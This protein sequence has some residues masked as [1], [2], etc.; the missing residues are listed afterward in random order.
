MGGVVLFLFLLA[1]CASIPKGGEQNDLPISR[2]EFAAKPFGFD[3]TLRNFEDNYK[4]VLKKQRYFITIPNTGRV[5]TIYNFHKGKKTKILFHKYGRFE[6][7]IIGGKIRR[8]Q[9]ELNNGIRTGLSRKEFFGKFTDWEYDESNSLILESP[10]IRCT[11]TF[12]FSRNKLKEIKFVVK[13][14]NT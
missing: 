14:P 3:L 9:I 1:S 4:N 11:F 13:R 12:V 10:S 7:R 6:G 5:D 2:E 8:P